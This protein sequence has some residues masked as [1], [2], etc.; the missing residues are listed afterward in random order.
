M[1]PLSLRLRLLGAAV[2]L[3][4]AG[5]GACEPAQ[6]AAA[7]PAASAASA[8]PGESEP[9]LADLVINGVPRGTYLIRPA[10]PG[11]FLLP[12]TD[13]PQLG[14]P[15]LPDPGPDRILEGVP[16]VSL[17]ALGLTQLR[18]DEITLTLHATL[19]PQWLPPQ[20]VDMRAQ[21]PT[22]SR[23]GPAPWSAFLNYRLQM[24]GGVGAVPL[25]LNAASELGVQHE[26]WFWQNETLHYRDPQGTRHVRA[27]TRLILDEPQTLR[28]WIVGDLT[29][30]ALEMGDS[31]GLGGV[32]VLKAY[33]IDPYLIRQPTASLQ[34]VLDGASQVDI[35]LN[36]VKVR[37]QNLAA[38]PFQ[39]R[40]LYAFNGFYD[41]TVI[42]R[43]RFGR[44]TQLS[45]PHY[46][47][48]QQLRQGLTEYGYY[49]GAQ[50]R[51]GSSGDARYAGLAGSG[52]HR[53]GVSDR[54]TL[55][56]QAQAAPERRL[57]GLSLL[58][59]D[60]RAGSLGAAVVAGQHA[61]QALRGSQISHTYQ[62]AQ[63]I[64]RAE[65][66]HNHRPGTEGATQPTD[67]VSLSLS[68]ALASWGQGS[69][70]VQRTR[71]RD[72]ADNSRLLMLGF[73]RPLWRESSLILSVTR[74]LGGSRAEGTQALLALTW[75]P[76]ARPGVL[77]SRLTSGD[78]TSDSLRIG[79]QMPLGEGQAWRLQAERQQSSLGG[80]QRV[81]PSW[82]INT[83]HA[84]Y[85]MQ[86]QMQRED[87]ASDTGWRSTPMLEVAGALSWLDGGWQWS[88]PIQDAFARV[89]VG[90]QPGVAVRLNGQPAGRT[91]AQ[92]RLF[93]PLVSSYLVN[94]I[95]I[96]DRD[97]PIDQQVESR[98]LRIRPRLR[99]GTVVDFA[100]A[101]WLTLKGRLLA[102]EP[103][104]LRPV[105]HADL[106]LA[107][108]RGQVVV[109]T[110]ASGEFYLDGLGPGRHELV[111]VQ[112]GRRCRLILEV[113]DASGNEIDLGELHVCRPEDRF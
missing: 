6:E 86:W 55:G 7:R 53:W 9:F 63:W 97:L 38:G 78:A 57:A 29:S 20:V 74:P 5:H 83:A 104:G 18:L 76:Q 39:I 103:Q 82:Q 91:D 25:Q 31:Y 90:Q 13:L 75:T 99:S 64:T 62:D 1:R 65:W 12:R 54:L 98:T 106:L 68:R 3:L 109:P 84:S 107:T 28:R 85:G 48:P 79:T 49:L 112:P 30:S 43:D 33:A 59:T 100:P 10:A 16:H 8:A 40:D 108:A 67:S 58:W 34:G 101:R 26:G 113:P 93:L 87:F 77:F 95:E 14:L 35:Y 50:R 92:G 81:T 94:Q 72:A 66:L 44:E 15:P 105:V 11:D 37:S 45:L 70:G 60:R 71:W 17:R 21:P 32:G 96:D 56:V 4:L 41:V 22:P 73:S 23:H 27:G 110:G 88:R 89:Q 51:S 111:V 2:A 52:F 42:A 46:F 61:G 19:P 102:V 69:V 24:T 80:T 36:G 47:N